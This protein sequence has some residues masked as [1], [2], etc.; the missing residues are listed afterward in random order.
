[1]AAVPALQVRL[2]KTPARRA[3]KVAPRTARA[4]ARRGA[5]A[6]TNPPQG[7]LAMALPETTTVPKAELV[8]SRMRPPVMPI[9]A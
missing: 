1:M 9:L 4:L 2:G 8:G 3:G 5:P 7:T 6:M